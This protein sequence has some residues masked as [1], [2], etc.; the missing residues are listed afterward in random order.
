MSRGRSFD[1]LYV[2]RLI[3]T[4]AVIAIHTTSQDMTLSLLGYYGNQLA[5][6]SVPMFL[7]LS[8]FLLFQSDLHDGFLPRVEFYRKRF[9]RILLPY[10]IW[11]IFYSLVLHYYFNGLQNSHLILPDMVRHLFLGNGFTH[12]YFVVI[13]IQLYLL[14]PFIRRGFEAHPGW[15]LLISLLLSLACQLVLYLNALKTI[16]LSG[17]YTQIY[18][19]AFPVWIFYFL[20]GMYLALN[21]QNLEL[22][23][24]FSWFSWTVGWVLSFA[25]LLWD[26]YKT[27]S[28]ALS[29]KPTVI[30]YATVS[31]FFMRAVL[32]RFPLKVG[33]FINWFSDQSFLIYLLHPLIANF[34]VFVSLRVMDQ[35][36][37]WSTSPG[38]SAKFLITLGLTLCATYVISLTPLAGALGGVKKKRTDHS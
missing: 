27:A 12:L 3:A 30:V 1:D 28:F 22:S 4:V 29:I 13:I 5:R 33:G 31:F 23:G 32:H 21:D 9:R 15:F 36:R 25:L 2:L 11:T 38:T 20:L 24:R 7:I 8:G 16:H 6:F 35:P 34:L 37:L 19:I 14:Y 26:S 18:L 17:A 10:I